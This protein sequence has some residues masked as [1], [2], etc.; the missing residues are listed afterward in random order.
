MGTELILWAL[1]SAIVGYF[2]SSR[3]TGFWGAFILSLILSPLIGFIITLISGKSTES[4]EELS[5]FKNLIN[6]GDKLAKEG[7]LELAI[8]K[9]NLALTHSNKAPKTNFKLAKLYSLTRDT[10]NSLKHLSQAIDQGFTEFEQIEQD[11]DLLY[12]RSSDEFETFKT[13]DYKIMADDF[14]TK[15]QLTEIQEVKLNNIKSTDEFIMLKNNNYKK[16]TQNIIIE[17]NSNMT[18][19]KQVLSFIFLVLGLITIYSIFTIMPEYGLEIGIGNFI[20][21]AILLAIAYWIYPKPETKDLLN[22]EEQINR[23]S[24]KDNKNVEDFVQSK[25]ISSENLKPIIVNNSKKHQRYKIFNPQY[26]IPI[27]II[28]VFIISFL[29][30]SKLGNK[31]NPTNELLYNNQNDKIQNEKIVINPQN[32]KNNRIEKPLT[33]DFSN[34][35]YK[36]LEVEEQRDFEAIYSFFSP[37]FSRYYTIFNP[38]YT[39]VKNKYEYTWSITSDAT[40]DVVNIE[41]INNYTY[42]LNTIFTFY[43]NKKHDYTTINSV[44]RFV[45]DERGKIVETYNLK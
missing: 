27:G 32:R 33:L 20:L 5:A 41:K 42:N 29:Y 23:N 34:V 12:L 40:N 44:V 21:P 17:R 28:L 11:N 37:H 22:T 10:Q 31:I 39:K 24:I 45:F 2:G 18:T 6:E 4:M 25:E 3:K 13:N 36:F 1:F 8:E 19:F 26:Y 15:I 43:S 9:Y 38:T 35:I 30:F 14:E 7:E 16:P